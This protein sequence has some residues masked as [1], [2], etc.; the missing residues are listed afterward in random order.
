MSL[1]ALGV[2]LESVDEE[3]E[4]RRGERG[5]RVAEVRGGEEVPDVDLV[6]QDV[7]PRGRRPARRML[8]GGRFF[9]PERSEDFGFGKN[10]GGADGGENWG[11]QRRNF[12]AERRLTCAGEEVEQWALLVVNGL[13]HVWLIFYFNFFSF[14]TVNGL[15]LSLSGPLHVKGNQRQ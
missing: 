3:A 4:I 6:E 14:L 2:G 8:T 1:N 11:L 15:R 12:E 5:A 9:Q 10:G 7:H 13:V